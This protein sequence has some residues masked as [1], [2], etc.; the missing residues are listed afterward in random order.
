MLKNN[1]K[2][3]LRSIFR[4]NLSYSLF[5]AD[6]TA[7]KF[8]VIVGEKMEKGV[9]L[10]VMLDIWER[11]MSFKVEKQV[12]QLRMVDFDPDSAKMVVLGE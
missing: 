5:R 3:K 2:F 10:E 1:V 7:F 4:K 6:Y 8:E 9:G 11:L 12:W